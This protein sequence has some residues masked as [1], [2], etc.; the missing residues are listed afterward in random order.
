MTELPTTLL[1]IS[2]VIFMSGNLLGMGLRLK[3]GE[4]LKG[5]RNIRFV[6]MTVLWG[7][8]LGPALAYLLTLLVPLKPPYA[9]GLIMI[10]MT[11]CAPFLPQMV[12]R[13][14]GDMSY[15]ASFMV[16]TSLIM[17][18]YM[19]LAVPLMIDGL[20]VSA[21]SVAKPLVTLV[22]IPLI[23]G[24]AIL[25][26]STAVAARLYPIIKI[27]TSS[28][29]IVLLLL[30]F[31]LYGEGFINS[32]GSFALATQIVFFSIVTFVP[33]QLALGLAQ[34]QKSVL[35][36]GLC[37]RNCGAAFAPLLSASNVD[38]RALVMVALA[39]PVQVVFSILAANWFRRRAKST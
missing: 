24:I 23:C 5:L 17:V 6:T 19:P 3:I 16:L 36:L 2:L 28:A 37:T 10:G 9:M 11:P 35:C 15:A 31:A 21:W 38:E 27:L 30:C 39:V 12:S 4:A 25:Q 7:F 13:A 22:L 32:A 26:A 18:I 20:S 1:K 33:Y 8:V 29:T 14:Q 34:D